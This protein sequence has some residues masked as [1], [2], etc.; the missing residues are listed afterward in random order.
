M[1]KGRRGVRSP[2]LSPLLDAGVGPGHLAADLDDDAD[3]ADHGPLRLMAMR[4]RRALSRRVMRP[5]KRLVD[6][7]WLRDDVEYVEA[8]F[9]SSVS[10]YFEYSEMLCNLAM[11][12]VL[13][14]LCVQIMSIVQH[15]EGADPGV[16]ER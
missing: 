1:A 7:I 2:R 16:E 12:N 3:D 4:L 14:W 5:L 13:I 15:V 9:G 10:V 6:R 11:G 8:R